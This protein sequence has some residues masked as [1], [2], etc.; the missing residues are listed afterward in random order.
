MARGA[1]KYGERNWEKGLPSS[2]YLASLMRHLEQFRAGDRIEDHLAAIRFNVDGL[3]H[4]EEEV[5]LGRYP[6]EL[7]DLDFYER[8]RKER[9]ISTD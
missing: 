1:R 9:D 4:N 2:W 8:E 7:L 5:A 6:D 3:M